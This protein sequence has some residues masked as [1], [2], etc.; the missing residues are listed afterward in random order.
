MKN[1]DLF[2]WSAEIR[3]LILIVL[4]ALVGGMLF[5]S[6]LLFFSV[7]VSIAAL[8]YLFQLSK[9]KHSLQDNAEVEATLDTGL[10]PGLGR[11]IAHLQQS[12]LEQERYNTQVVSLFRKAFEVFPD[13]VMILRPDWHIRWCN[14]AAREMFALDPDSEV[15][16]SLVEEAGH[17]VLK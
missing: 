11:E 9:L 14:R 15:F 10:L 8:W 4:F 13:A 12:M 7:G 1:V 6:Y 2:E 17:P 16:G 3:T 5:Q